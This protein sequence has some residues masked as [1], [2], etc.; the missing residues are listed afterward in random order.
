MLFCAYL[1]ERLSEQRLS[2]YFDQ[3]KQV[4]N[5][6]R[7]IKNAKQRTIEKHKYELQNMND[8]IRFLK[9]I[10]NDKQLVLHNYDKCMFFNLYFDKIYVLNL[11]RQPDKW[12]RTKTHLEQHYLFDDV[13]F[14][15]IDGK[16]PENV[17]KWNNHITEMKKKY[18]AKSVEQLPFGKYIPTTGSYA[19]LESVRNILLD[20]KHNRYEMVVIFQ[21]D[22]VLHNQFCQKFHKF[23]LNNIVKPQNDEWK[24]IYLGA[25]Q[26]E[27][28]DELSIQSQQYYVPIG[29]TDGAFGLILHERVYDELLDEISKMETS[30]DSGA[31]SNIQRKS[32]DIYKEKCVNQHQS[33][34]SHPNP[35]V[36]VCYPNLV[37]SDVSTS[38][39]RKPRSMIETAKQF[40]W[41]L[42]DYD[43]KERTFY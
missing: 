40:R 18:R 21:D 37:I 16:K 29:T 43:I 9:N 39:L 11:D 15:G 1:Y 5:G 17:T 28:S 38:D 8:N 35:Q 22:V 12:N 42:N 24:I 25:S 2:D 27:W 4:M 26:H 13:R 41:N 6:K 14:A 7:L 32:Y 34:N 20:A 3:A 23:Y 30:I 19:I 31:L 36:M 33:S 10:I